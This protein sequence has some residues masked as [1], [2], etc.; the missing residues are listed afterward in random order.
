MSDKEMRIEMSDVSLFK[1]SFWLGRLIWIT[2]SPTRDNQRKVTELLSDCGILPSEILRLESGQ[3]VDMFSRGMAR[4]IIDRY[5]VLVIHGFE[6]ANSGSA[7]S[8]LKSIQSFCDLRDGHSLQ[9]ILMSDTVISP[10]LKR[11]EQ[12][13]P[14]E[15]S[16]DPE[17]SDP[18]EMNERVHNLL[19]L[20]MQFSGVSV[21]RISERAAVFL[22]EFVG[23]EG[24][25]DAFVLMVRGMMRAKT[26]ELTLGDLTP[27]VFEF[28]DANYPTEK[29]CF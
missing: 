6:D 21:N 18:G 25:T 14:T 24:D 19:D 8:L 10:E 7:N 2:A 3:F 29:A 23:E 1:K 17:S 4:D 11:F 9:L 28:D 26:S 13:K 22:E 15:I 12:F 27:Q 5:E 20:A 16:I